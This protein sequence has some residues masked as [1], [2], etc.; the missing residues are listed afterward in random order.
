MI[1]IHILPLSC[2]VVVK[3]YEV[4]NT[5]WTQ[6]T[7]EELK[8]SELKNMKTKGHTHT[9]KHK[10]TRTYMFDMV[11]AVCAPNTHSKLLK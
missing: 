1:F 3:L 2:S 10:F 5:S 9:R 8:R 4:Y 11:H 6:H 7:A